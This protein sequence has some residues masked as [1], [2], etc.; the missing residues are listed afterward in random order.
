MSRFT[1]AI[2]T[3]WL[4]S[5][6]ALAETSLAQDNES[7][8]ESNAEVVAGSNAELT[9]SELSTPPSGHLDFPASRPAW[10]DQPPQWEGEKHRLPVV[11]TPS[12]TK[13]LSEEALKVQLRAAFETYVETLTG[14]ENVSQWLQVSDQ[15]IDE[16][17]DPSRRYAGEIRVGDETLHESATVLI[18]D[19]SDRQWI[20][21]QHRLHQVGHRVGVVGVAA[22]SMMLVLLVVSAGLS[23]VAR[24][25][26]R[27]VATTQGRVEGIA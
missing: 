22:A 13:S 23:T 17:Q 10:I 27:R 16:R 15:W 24:R 11:S 3:A 6:A 21:H 20:E 14:A 5:I 26:E 25:A 2:L 1:L 9:T 4:F 12:R 8:D 19:R 18:L 7:A